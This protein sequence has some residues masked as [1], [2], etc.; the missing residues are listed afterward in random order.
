MICSYQILLT[1]STVVVS[2][3]AA[4]C[5][6]YQTDAGSTFTNYNFFDFRGGQPQGYGE[7]FD[8]LDT[9]YNVQDVKNRMT[10][11]NVVVRKA[12]CLSRQTPQSILSSISQIFR[13]NLMLI[14]QTT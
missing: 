2:A 4:D 6:C 1:L 14:A 12:P 5:P 9:D 13:R 10:K 3:L 7:I 11:G 8:Q